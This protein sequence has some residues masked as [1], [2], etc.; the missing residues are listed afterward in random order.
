M[1]AFFRSFFASFLAL[2]VLIALVIGIIT[3]RSSRKPKIRD[4]SFLIV[5]IHGQILE[6]DPPADIVSQLLERDPLTLQ[7]ILENLEK[8]S[9]DDRID[10]V[11]LKLSSSNS[12]G[13]AKLHEI[14]RAVRKVQEARKKVYGFSDAIDRKTYYLAAAC[15]SIIVPPPSYIIFTGF[16]TTTEHFKGSLE[17]LGIEP[18]VHRI[19]D[20]KSAAEMVIRK[21]MSRES[22]ENKTWILEEYWDMFAETLAKDRELSEEEIEDLMEHALFTAEEAQER[23]LIDQIL[24]WDE[25]EQILTGEEGRELR[26]VS[27]ARYVQ[28]DPEKFGFKGKKKIAVIHAQGT[29]A[30]RE[31]G[32]N[33]AL[34]VTMG[35]ETVVADLRRARLNED[36]AAVVFRVD[37]RGGEGL[38]SDL[39]GHEVEVLSKVKPTVVSMVDVAG[40]GGYYISYQ[41]S[42]V[43]A[44]SFTLTGSIGS[45]S[46]KGNLKGLYDKLGITQDFV[47]WGPMALLFSEYRDFTKEEWERFV[48]NHWDGFN[49]WLKDVAEHRGMTF[50]EAEKLAHGRVW[51][52]RQAEANGLV[53]DLGGLDRA[54]EIAKELAGIP[55]EEKV[56]LVHYPKKK[57][58]IRTI[59]GQNNNK[60]TIMRWLMYQSLQED[61]Q[62]TIKWLTE[63]PRYLMD[64]IKLN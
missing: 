22:R 26:T 55:A 20:Y 10:G 15:D 39:I 60:P 45:I 43:V 24:Y 56:T 52:G 47:T 27:L 28:E 37:S 46:G 41:A 48:D 19:K 36:I 2:T 35:H 11:I 57:G 33:P 4:H 49:A 42:R 29:I 7:K 30:G 64:D 38:G 13:M 12:A 58:I 6:Y 62:Q 25:L 50:E 14:R 18:N 54:V 1:K 8:A 59:F 40:S 23:G 53:D 61:I 16:L 51:T 34:G 32:V 5:D 44:D 3:W 63:E 9:V 31:S 21:D 17:K